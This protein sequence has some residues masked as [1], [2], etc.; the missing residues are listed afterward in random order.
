[1]SLLSA[2]HDTLTIYTQVQSTDEDGNTIY[3]DGSNFQVTCTVRPIT[4]DS[5]EGNHNITTYDCFCTPL[6]DALTET[7]W[8]HCVWKG[9]PYDI[10]ATP[11]TTTRSAR[12]AQTRWQI[13]SRAKGSGVGS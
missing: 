7:E 1:M 13:R 11:Y 3:T 12:T 10:V 5:T 9:A 4:T 8:A 2:G 6:P